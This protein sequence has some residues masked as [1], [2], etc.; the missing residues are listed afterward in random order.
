MVGAVSGVN[1]RD[2]R[3][4]AECDCGW[5]ALAVET[6]ESAQHLLDI[7]E[8][9]G[10]CQDCGGPLAPGESNPCETCEAEG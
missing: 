2:E 9:D 6:V 10:H 1:M 8:G 7:H 4:D 3:Y 5:A